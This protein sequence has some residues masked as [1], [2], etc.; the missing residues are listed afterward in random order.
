MKYAS[1]RLAEIRNFHAI[2]DKLGSAG[3]PDED[4]FQLISEAGF[5]AVINLALTTSDN[6][7][8]DEGSIVTSLGMAYFHILVDFQSP[9][10]KDFRLFCQLMDAFDG[11]PV[12]IHCAA[13]MRVSAFV[14]LYRVLVQ[15]VAN[16]DAEQDLHAIWHLNPTWKQFID[17]QLIQ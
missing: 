7:I 14:F 4:Q 5:E 2:S 11:R 13:N 6:A 3:Q 10:S 1:S 8:P 17:E 12:F 16:A 9:Q 15:G